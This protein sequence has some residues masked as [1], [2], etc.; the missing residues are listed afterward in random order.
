[1]AETKP[2][3][4]KTETF[5][6]LVKVRAKME[7]ESGERASMDSVINHILNKINAK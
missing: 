7:M 1:M 3:Q 2:I 6:A 5:K 4:V